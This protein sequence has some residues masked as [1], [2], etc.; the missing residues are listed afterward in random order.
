MK[1]EHT[2]GLLLRV[3]KTVT[4]TKA[5]VRHSRQQYSELTRNAII[6]FTCLAISSPLMVRA[7]ADGG[8]VINESLVQAAMTVGGSIEI[9]GGITMR[10]STTGTH[11][12]DGQPMAD[13]HLTSEMGKIAVKWDNRRVMQSTTDPA[14]ATLRLASGSGMIN[15]RM[16]PETGNWKEDGWLVCPS[17]PCNGQI[18]VVGNQDTAPGDYVV[19]LTYANYY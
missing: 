6:A 8:V 13:Y 17:T 12:T 19:S 1:T 16:I 11:L 18:A 2:Q 14:Q 7:T 10:T 5:Y 4:H 9:T 3:Y 15:V